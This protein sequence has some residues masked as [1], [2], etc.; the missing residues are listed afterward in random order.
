ML[1]KRFS[2]WDVMDSLIEGR[3]SN[4]SKESNCAMRS[5]TSDL[6]LY[7]TE[8]RA[9]CI[10]KA[11]NPVDRFLAPLL[12][13][14]P[15]RLSRVFD[16]EGG[17]LLLRGA[18]DRFIPPKGPSL[19]WRGGRPLGADLGGRCLTVEESVIRA[20]RGFWAWDSVRVAPHDEKV[21]CTLRLCN[22]YS[23][24]RHCA[25]LLKCRATLDMGFV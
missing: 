1:V 10:F 23:H 3:R 2:T 12:G 21:V 16:L 15:G 4:V 8:L 13:P 18:S 17:N 11:L 6:W 7:E 5:L 24:S 19:C 20:G 22:L 9:L 14:S 25:G